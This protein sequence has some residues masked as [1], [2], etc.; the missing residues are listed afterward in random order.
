M[1]TAI[2]IGASRKAVVEARRAVLKIM[3]QPRDEATIRKALN[4]FCSV[5]QVKGVTIQNCR[6]RA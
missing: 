5:T 6:F 2:K 4:V 3:K 1:K